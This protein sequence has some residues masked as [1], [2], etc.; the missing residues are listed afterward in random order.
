MTILGNRKDVGRVVLSL[1]VIV[2]SSLSAAAQDH[3]FLGQKFDCVIEPFVIV[4]VGSAAEGILATVNV[5]RG[6]IVRKGEVIATLNSDIEEESVNLARLRAENNTAIELA[7]SRLEFFSKKEAR[8]RKLHSNRVISIEAMDRVETELTLAELELDKAQ[9]DR[10]IANTE[11][12]RSIAFQ[13]QRTIRSPID[14]V[15]MLRHMN[16]GEFVHDQSKI[17][18]LAQMD[19]LRVEL[20]LPIATYGQVHD[21]TAVDVYPVVPVA[22][23][24]RAL[25]ETVDSVFDP[26]SGTFGVRLVLPNTDYQLPAGIKCKAQFLPEGTTLNVAPSPDDDQMSVS[27][28]AEDTE[29]TRAGSAAAAAAAD[30]TPLP[31]QTV[32]ISFSLILLLQRQLLV[33]GFDPGPPDGILGLRTRAAINAFQEQHSLSVEDEISYALLE[34]MRAAE[35]SM[36]APPSR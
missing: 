26:A 2:V 29:D 28:R 25:I 21:G 9:L 1:V 13:A 5:D 6:K 34:L 15:V 24:Y 20:H 31:P 12:Q 33:L 14:A 32:T 8:Q 11:L 3:K 18:M 22:G 30:R 36:N 4:E 17:V 19:P 23:R 7:E 27:V 16:P 35:A 10:R